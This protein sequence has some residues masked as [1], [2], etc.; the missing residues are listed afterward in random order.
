MQVTFDGPYSEDLASFKNLVQDPEKGVY[1][2]KGST[3][4]RAS[5]N[6]IKNMRKQPDLETRMPFIIRYIED[7]LPPRADYVEAPEDFLDVYCK[8][9]L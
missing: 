3:K 9:E 6:A 8:V 5:Q 4:V 7:S 2:G 1:I